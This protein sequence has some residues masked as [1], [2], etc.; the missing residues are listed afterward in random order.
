MESNEPRPMTLED[1]R[2]IQEGMAEGQRR[3]E[4]MLLTAAKE[5]SSVDRS[6]WVTM[7]PLRDDFDYDWV[8]QWLSVPVKELPQMVGAY[9]QMIETERTNRLCKCEW[10]VH[11]DDVGKP[12]GSRRVHRGA[13]ATDCPVHTKIGFLLYF[14]VHY[15]KTECR[16]CPPDCKTCSFDADCECYEHQPGEHYESE[17][18][19]L[20][21]VCGNDWICPESQFY[22]ID[23]DEPKSPTSSMVT[24]ELP[25]DN[26]P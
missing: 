22:A 12:V 7:Y 19:P 2:Q 17:R 3:R 24:V 4:E 14:F 23:V 21:C 6:D 20:K 18:H 13:Q 25:S 15:F 11:P 1:W 8:G 9:V 26:Q 5:L 16:Y 10:I